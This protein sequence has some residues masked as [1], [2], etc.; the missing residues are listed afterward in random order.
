MKIQLCC[1]LEDDDHLIT[2]PQEC[3]FLAL[4]NV[5]EP[6]RFS[7]EL[8]ML[9]TGGWRALVG[10]VQAWPGLP[11]GWTGHIEPEPWERWGVPWP[12]VDLVRWPTL[13]QGERVPSWPDVSSPAGE[14]G[15][16]T[17][18]SELW[19]G[20]SSPRNAIPLFLVVFFFVFCFFFYFLERVGIT[21]RD[22]SLE[23]FISLV[24][25]LLHSSYSLAAKEWVG[26]TSLRFFFLFLNW[27][28]VNL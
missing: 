26:Q 9:D 17:A 6:C 12:S 18:P 15:R 2:N 7:A 5:G 27:N 25:D 3:Y 23:L 21:H 4:L 16:F 22:V 24:E 1:V 10:S 13:W 20:E 11:G 8:D 28:I 14:K 19:S